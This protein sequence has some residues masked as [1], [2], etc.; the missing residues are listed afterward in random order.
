[1]FD[2]KTSVTKVANCGDHSRLPGLKC[3][4]FWMLRS[5]LVTMM[6]RFNLATLCT[7]QS[8]ISFD[9]IFVLITVDQEPECK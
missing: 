1:M 5:D 6:V 8:L 9:S 7:C 3:T 2:G 4:I